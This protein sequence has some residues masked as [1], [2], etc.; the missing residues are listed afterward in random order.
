MLTSVVLALLL[1]GCGSDVPKQ[2][3]TRLI[4]NAVIHDGTGSEPI[5]GDL[6]FDAE[7]GRILEVGNLDATGGETVFDANGLALAPG[8][9][10]PH[11]HHDSDYDTFR[12]MPGVLSQGV[13]TIV[14]GVDGGSEHGSVADFIGAFNANPAAVNIASLSPHNE[15]RA[16]VMGDDYRRHA[17]ATEIQA[18]AALVEADMQAGAVGISTGLE[19]E[20]GIYSETGEIVALAQVAADFGGIY[21]THMRDEDDRIFEAVDEALRIGR[22]A[23]LP[24]H[25]TH[26]KL[27]DRFFWGLTD[28]LLGKLEAARQEGIRASADIYP[29]ERWASNLAVLF[30]ERDYTDRAAGETALE[31]SAAAEDIFITHY[32]ANPELVGLTVDEIA[33][34][35]QRDPVTTLLELSSDA[36]AHRQETGEDAGIIARSMTDADITAFIQWPYMGIGSDGWHGDHPRG[37]GSFPRV[38]GRFVRERGVISLPEAIYKMT[39]LNADAVGIPDRGRIAAGNFADLV[40]FDPNAI[41]DNATMHDPMAMSSGI[42]MVWVNG[43]LAF[44]DGRPS[45][46][47]AGQVVSRAE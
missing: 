2:V 44:A 36:E 46:T 17:S 6:R 1:S 21:H 30:P 37:Y 34:K 39:G 31:R 5:E 25:I 38:L 27:A 9:I 10:D 20:P 42:E 33:K 35:T 18:M 22:E 16:R 4:V 47:F 14:R 13:T 11:S 41:I 45:G 12:H 15:I 32:P 43:Q 7:T 26:V 3:S 29:Y 19:Y 24:V 28:M 40:L 23:G 8:F